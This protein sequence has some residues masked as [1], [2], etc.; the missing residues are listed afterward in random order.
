M[1]KNLVIVESPA[2]AKTIKKYLGKDFEV[3]ASVGHVR[4]LPKSN[5]G[6]DVDSGFEPTYV[7]SKGKEKV[8]QELKKAA[9]KA[10]EIYLATDPDR[11]GEAIA[12]HIREALKRKGRVFHRV[13]FHEI[14]KDAVKEA[15]AEPE[16]LNASR[17]ESQQARRIL[18]RLVGYNISPLLWDKVKRGLSAGRVQSVALRVIVEREREIQ[19]FV[20]KEYWSLTAALKADTP[21]P[22]QS[23]LH[24]IGKKKAELANEE[25]TT[26]VV[27]RV[28]EA[29]WSVAKVTKKR[30][31]RGPLAPLVTSTMQMEAFNK[32]GFPAGKTMS[33]AQKLYEG[34]DMKDQGTAGLITYMRTDSTRISPA[35]QAEAKQFIIDRF[36]AEYAPKKA[37]VFKS[38][39]R[40]QDAHEAIRP[41]SALRTP[42][43]MAKFLPKDAAALYGLVWRR[44]MASQ[45][46]AAQIDQTSIDIAAADCTFRSSGSIFAFKGW[47]ELWPADEKEGNGLPDLTEGEK[48]KLDKL[49][50]K[51]HFTQP[52]PRYTDASLV[53]E[54]EDKGIGRPSTYASILTTLQDKEYAERIKGRFHPSELGM[55]VTD[56]L[57]K[58]FPQLLDSDFTAKMENDLDRVEEGDQGWQDTL[59]Q[60]YDP[61][62]KDLEQARESM[63]DLKGQGLA[64]DVKCPTCGKPMNIRLGRAGQ[65]LACTGYPECKTTRDFT[66]QE[67]GSIKPDEVEEINEECPNCGQPMQVK[68]G[69]FGKFLACTGYPDCKTTKPMPGEERERQEP[70]PTDEI[71][72]KC[73]APMVIKRSRWGSQFIAC[74]AYPKCKNSKP[75][76]TGIKCPKEDCG[77]DLVERS[78]KRGRKFYGCSNYPKCDYVVWQRPIDR[79]CPECE[80]PFMLLKQLKA[81]PTLACPEKGC[82]HK[83]PA[84]DDI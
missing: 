72:D 60:F 11:E 41:T 19:A 51:Q 69:R 57:V 71:C 15:L 34:I 82:G 9:D 56:L 54:L 8:V 22:F 47:R 16:E 21:P 81:G 77:G 45:M 39:K 27:D 53:K 65:F 26:A 4:D 67:D 73:G 6:V 40:A 80:H 13:M 70:I 36:G 58:S 84:P 68:S 83:E 63:A 37:N 14:T 31:R 12:W 43:Q 32:L 50:P 44:F 29:E 42:E 3:K 10:T 28:R 20:P 18:D 1:A 76:P 23:K 78:S 33:L 55:V 52:P 49:D 75:L 24:K 17:F 48:L 5:I 64:T 59:G 35:A 62:V 61:F 46:A 30:V 2:K 25:E 38:P 66:R 7:V 79:K 74:S